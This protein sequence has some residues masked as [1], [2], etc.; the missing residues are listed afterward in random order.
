MYE[1]WCSHRETYNKPSSSSSVV[2]GHVRGADV[3]FSRRYD[4]NLY[5]GAPSTTI[6]CHLHPCHLLPRFWM[7]GWRQKWQQ[8]PLAKLRSD[9]VVATRWFLCLVAIVFST[10]LGDHGHAVDHDLLR[11]LHVALLRLPLPLDLV[12]RTQRL[13][14]SIR[15]GDRL[16][17]VQH[18]NTVSPTASASERRNAGRARARVCARREDC[19]A[20]DSAHRLAT[21][22]QEHSGEAGRDKRCGMQKAGQRVVGQQ[23]A[24]GSLTVS[25]APS[26]S[27]CLA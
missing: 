22:R 2:L 25:S 7:L 4:Y 15:L 23:A 19:A 1:Q 21:A 14:R 26:R 17:P 12:D 18:A 16:L 13:P 27:Q 9:E 8:A 20:S 3:V 11:H 10:R 6:P 24:C 5:L